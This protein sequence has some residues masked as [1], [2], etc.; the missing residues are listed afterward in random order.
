VP[1]ASEPEPGCET[2]GSGADGPAQSG[3]AQSAELEKSVSDAP[4]PTGPVDLAR[5]QGPS[6]GLSWSYELDLAGLLAAIGGVQAGDPSDQET[7]LAEELECKEAGPGR[8][9][10][11]V[12]AD[13]LPAGPGL[14]GWLANADLGALSDWDL[15]G[16]AAAYRR[17][18]SWAAAGELAAVASMVSR[19]A[20][21]DTRAEVDAEGR[22]DRVTAGAACEVSLALRMSQA[23]ASWHARLG[24]DLAWRLRETGT[25]LAA[26]TI[27]LPRARL[28]AEA[29]AVLTD[30]DARAVE[31]LVLPGAGRQTTGQLR[32]ALRRAV[33]RVDP[34][35]AEERRENA[36][37]QATV[38]L[39]PDQVGTAALVASNLPGV[40]A[41]AMM[42]R[43]SA[44]ARGMK[45][46]G[47]GGGIGLLRAMALAGL[48]LGTLPLTP[49]PPGGPPNPSPDNPGPAGG[50]DP[51]PG[52]GDDGQD[53]LGGLDG[54]GRGYRRRP[55]DL[56]GDG[57]PRGGRSGGSSRRSRRPDHKLARP[58]SCDTGP[59]QDPGAPPGGCPPGS[60][61]SPPGPAPAD[62][63]PPLTDALDHD[64]GYALDH[65]D[66]HAL[67]H[68]DGHDD[69][70]DRPLPG[71]CDGWDRPCDDDYD[72]SIIPPWPPLPDTMAEIP[73]FLG[74]PPRRYPPGSGLCPPTTPGRPDAPGV[75]G[76]RPTAGLLDL[77]LSWHVL[78][79]NPG[80]PASLGRL[81]PI[82]A[83][84]A[85]ALAIPAVPDPH[86]QWR[87]VLTDPAGQAIAVDR[88][89]RGQLCDNP[90]RPPG[91]TGRVTVIVPA[92]AL[93]SHPPP[94]TGEKGG[95]GNDQETET[96]V[97]AGTTQPEAGTGRGI[98][99]AVLRAAA[100]AATQAADTAAADGAA[101]GCAHATATP[102]YRPTTRIRE[103]VT[104][105]DQTCR[106][107][108]CGQPAW[109]AD[110]DHTQPWHRGGPT[111]RCNL[112][113]G[114]R[115]H[116]QIKQLP[117]W[118][119]T[120]P[121]PGIFTWI[122]PAG[123]TYTTTPDPYPI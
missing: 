37:R 109:R 53:G 111:C 115:T 106:Q 42:A 84:Q 102:A 86:A 87:V 60:R 41:A 59:G 38:S 120:Q 43:L 20:A 75:P 103:H 67:D 48:V 76:G 64:D 35:G 54:G 3:S 29:T 22:P 44:I 6:E 1:E 21:R 110:L 49:A 12:I 52:P 122:T 82:S 79:G 112:G 30:D 78:T 25:A 93:N 32:G 14:A 39:Y 118:T 62:S 36:E 68:D 9:L 46:G 69:G 123:R 24:V 45:A 63:G 66:G 113:G 70:Q 73:P 107:P 26:G 96:S 85:L 18:A 98:R 31:A 11:G 81:G 119:L 91:V 13:Q 27:D 40:Q 56:T 105:R 114:C 7:S 8:D 58:H 89:R 50:D 95:A 15:P 92:A 104:A 100:R 33:L 28:I 74:G 4:E 88:I 121:A 97:D 2:V 5:A 10:A 47:A 17:V 57:P 99:A 83:A 23:S 101:G 90:G 16:I 94:G 108:Y 80:A 65:D 61:P 71:A 34:K 72:G 19:T 51:D 77:T 117:G 116:H 55:P